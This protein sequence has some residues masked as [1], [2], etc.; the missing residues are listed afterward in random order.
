LID[1]LCV[2]P[3]TVIGTLMKPVRIEIAT[4]AE[5]EL[6]EIAHV[7]IKEKPRDMRSSMIDRSRGPLQVLCYI[8]KSS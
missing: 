6:D 5:D 4:F 8:C 7:V 2:A 3:K 1:I